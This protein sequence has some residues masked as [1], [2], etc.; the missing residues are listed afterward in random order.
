MRKKYQYMRTNCT[1]WLGILVVV[2][3]GL[4][5]SNRTDLTVQ[6]LSV[7]RQL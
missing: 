2:L 3:A 7:G 6:V 4:S 1:V 5:Q